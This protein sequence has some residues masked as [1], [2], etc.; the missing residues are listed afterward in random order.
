MTI[1]HLVLSGGGPILIQLLASIQ[2][3]E[4]KH[5]LSMS[6]IETM[7]GTSAGAIVAVMISLG[8]DWE[9]LNNYVIKRRWN[10]IFPIH[11]Q[12]ILNS[13]SNKGIFN[14]T[15]IE[16]CFKP[17]FEAKDISVDITL[18][19]FFTLTNREIHMYSFEINEYVLHD[20][21][22]KTHPDLPVIQALHMTC[23]MPVLIAPVFMENGCYIDGGVACNYP[24][25]YCIESGHNP[26]E[27][28]GFTNK[29]SNV[30][31]VVN[32]NSNLLDFILTFLFKSIFNIHNNFIQ[33][34]IKNVVNCNTECLSLHT[35]QAALTNIDV[36]KSL[37]EQGIHDATAFLQENN[38]A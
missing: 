19:D 32:E 22:Y 28:V 4:N 13:Y 5:F 7:Y 18:K 37:F 24:L 8:F 2:E 10:E 33:P 3:L 15:P 25:N 21:S 6:N 26:D 23:A 35:I 11:V 34:N 16:K 27:I 36:R 9:T 31:S 17:L 14:R 1:K 20:I 12:D 30:K 38:S 29:Y